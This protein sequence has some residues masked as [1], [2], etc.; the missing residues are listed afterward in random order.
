MATAQPK[1]TLTIGVDPISPLLG[2]WNFQTE[3][4]VSPKYSVYL[5]FGFAA[6]NS[7]LLSDF[8]FYKANKLDV[9]MRY[10]FETGFGNNK[11]TKISQNTFL[12]TGF[13]FVNQEYDQPYVDRVVDESGS[14]LKLEEFVYK[15]INRGALYYLGLGKKMNAGRLFF[16]AQ[17][18]FG[19]GFKE[20][21]WSYSGN[22]EPYI[23]PEDP[24]EFTGF[25]LFYPGHFSAGTYMSLNLGC[26][27]Y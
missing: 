27:L 17:A 22:L 5:N 19:L 26:R 20:N 4:G 2:L 25:I 11:A 13:K 24:M 14:I 10:Y 15:R 16:E 21:N 3:L 1:S 18:G 7:P 8:D 23:F 6:K 9:G 12:Q